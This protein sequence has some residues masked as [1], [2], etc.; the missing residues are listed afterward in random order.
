M[1]RKNTA[2]QAR[3]D[4]RAAQ[5]Q[6]QV[7]AERRRTQ[8]IIA[9]FVV[10]V[11]GGIGLLYFLTNPPNWFGGNSSTGSAATIGVANGV[12]VG[13]SQG[14][15][16]TVTDEG[17]GHSVR[18]QRVKYTHQPPS[19]GMHYSDPGAPHLPWGALQNELLPEE[20]VHNLE[21]GG[22]V[23]VYRCSGSE[24]DAAYGAAQ[25]LFSAMPKEPQFG[26]VKFL[27]V[28]YQAMSPKVALLAWDHEQDFNG[29]PTVADTTAFYQLFVD[30][31]PEAVQ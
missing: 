19:S 3:L 10:L 17:R 31:G 7:A 24:C 26:E 29:I 15:V 28:P 23:L 13:K 5:I 18:P 27:S 30:K 12:G 16:Q 9:V 11:V 20:F 1:A 14:T 22:I 6:A 2:K 8:V 21:H 4:E 25:A